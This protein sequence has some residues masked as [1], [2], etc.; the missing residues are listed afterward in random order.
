MHV[1][2]APQHLEEEPLVVLRLQV[3][4]E[5]DDLHSRTTL[6]LVLVSLVLGLRELSSKTRRNTCLVQ[7]RLHEL[8]HKCQLPKFLVLGQHNALELNHVCTGE[9]QTRQVEI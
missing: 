4:V 6:H 3:M 2:E 7:V 1:A 9:C 5:L 8:K